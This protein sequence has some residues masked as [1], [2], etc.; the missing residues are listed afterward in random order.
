M[1]PKERYASLDLARFIAALIVFA[2]HMVFL[3]KEIYWTSNALVLL[4]PISTGA[5]AVLFFFALSG[6]VLSFQNSKLNY[7]DWTKRRLIRL[8]PVYLISWLSGLSLVIAHDTNLLSI[9]ALVLGVLGLQS[10]SQESSMVVNAPLWSLSVEIIFAFFLYFLIKLRDRPIYLVLIIVIDLVI[11]KELFS[12]IIVDALPYFAIGILLRNEKILRIKVRRIFV[13]SILL[14][15][16]VY[17]LLIGAGQI[18]I[19]PNTLIGDVCLILGMFLFLFLLSRFQI[20]P[21][22]SKLAIALGKR[23]FCLYA[24]HYPVLLVFNYFLSP[25]TGTQ[26]ALYSGLSIA[27]TCIATE[28]GYRLIDIPSTAAAQ[29]RNT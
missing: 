26:F 27:S 9:Q 21:N 15:A 23:S 3:P 29:R 22:L 7:V 11:L 18:K 1:Q 14:S 13:N 28:L 4:S 8:Y 6:F 17:Y 5:I 12:S 25:S 2:G 24:F 19:W 10:F 16:T 20:N